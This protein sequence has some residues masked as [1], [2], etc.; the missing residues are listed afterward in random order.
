VRTTAPR[1][2]FALCVSY[3]DGFRRLPETVPYFLEQ[4]Q[5]IGDAQRSDLRA[6]GAHAI[7]LRSSS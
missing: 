3:G 2:F 7:I 1:K 6:H 4:V 5:P